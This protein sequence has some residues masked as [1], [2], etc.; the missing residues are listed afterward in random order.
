[1]ASLS[2]PRQWRSEASTLLTAI[3]VHAAGSQPWRARVW[4]CIG[5]RAHIQK[6][7]SLSLTWS[8]ETEPLTEPETCGV[9]FVLVPPHNTRIALDFVMGVGEFKVLELVQ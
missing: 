2:S 9:C 3:A 8:L 1:M 6:S 5:P 4:G 7:C